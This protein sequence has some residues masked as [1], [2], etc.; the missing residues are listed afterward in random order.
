M[1]FV[2][3]LT[4]AEAELLRQFRKSGLT[5]RERER[6]HALL[7]SARGYTR[8]Q[9]ADIFDVDNDTISGWIDRWHERGLDALADAPKSG[10]PSKLD[11]PAQ[12]QV[13]DA[14]ERPAPHLK[15]RVLPDLKKK[16]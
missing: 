7:L 10:R 14:L 2:Q 13:R 3:P 6:A 11:A 12:Q 8:E 1:K 16:A 15:A 5:Q 9:L 4:P